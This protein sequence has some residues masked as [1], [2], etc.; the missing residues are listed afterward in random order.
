MKGSLVGAICAVLVLTLAVGAFATLHDTD[1]GI[2]HA[3]DP[4]DVSEYGDPGDPMPPSSSG[5]FDVEVKCLS[6]ATTPG[7]AIIVHAYHSDPEQDTTFELDPG[8]P[9]PE[10]LHCNWVRVEIEYHPGG[11]PEGMAGWGVTWT[12]TSP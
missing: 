2:V 12:P 3:G 5:C 4:P 6:G 11:P 8:E 10:E 1:T 7:A 9:M